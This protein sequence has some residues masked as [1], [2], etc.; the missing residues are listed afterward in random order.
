MEDAALEISQEILSSNTKYLPKQL[1]SLGGHLDLRA[2]HLRALVQHLRTGAFGH[3]SK[4]ILWQLLQ[5]AEKLE[6][7]KAV[8]AAHN[9][10]LQE[11]P[12]AGEGALG[13]VINQFLMPAQTSNDPVRQWFLTDVVHIDKLLRYTKKTFASMPDKGRKQQLQIGIADSEANEMLIGGLMKAWAF[14][15]DN[16]ELYNL[17]GPNGI[18]LNGLLVKSDGFPA[19]WTSEPLLL[20]AL[21]NSRDLSE[22]TLEALWEPTNDAKQT[23]VVEKIAKQLMHLAEFCCRA[24]EER[25]NWCLQQTKLGDEVQIEGHAVRERYV[26]CRGD[27]IKPL[28]KYGLSKE[29]FGIAEDYES[30]RTLVEMCSEKMREVDAE[31]IALG[32]SNQEGEAATKLKAI[33]LKLQQR[34]EGYFEKFGEPFAFEMY[35]YLVENNQLH[36]LLT[37]FEA[38]REQFL[39]PYLRKNPKYSKLSWMHDISLGQFNTAADTLYAIAT[40]KEEVLAHQRIELSIGKLAKLAAL[41]R[42][43]I[44]QDAVDLEMENY[45]IKLE[46]IKAQQKIRTAVDNVVRNAIDV[47]AAVQLAT[48]EYGKKLKKLPALRGLFQN[49]FKDLV[50]GKALAPMD[51][52]ELITLMESN[53]EEFLEGKQYYVAL[54]VMGYAAST[55]AQTRIMEKTIWRRCFLRDE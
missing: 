48:E 38:W 37:G 4:E 39:T 41:E 53:D 5:D 1:P 49:L 33:K 50:L 40:K 3:A 26:G 31:L 7:A 14:R 52:V 35:E 17:S 27:W 54:Q 25:A 51:L 9:Q 19:P 29:A 44:Q 18:N 16:A 10:L 8:W 36:T 43:G 55:V 6:A 24:F 22:A 21:S 32:P 30:F 2:L 15:V 11:Y 46:I 34:L 42:A 45:N 12:N 23:E 20:Q 13:Q 28:V 47:D